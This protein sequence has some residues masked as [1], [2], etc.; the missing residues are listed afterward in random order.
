MQAWGILSATELVADYQ[1]IAWSGS[2]MST[3]STAQNFHVPP[4]DWGM[5]Y[6]LITHVFEQVGL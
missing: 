5:K 1:L 3:Y 2:G 4:E 6:P